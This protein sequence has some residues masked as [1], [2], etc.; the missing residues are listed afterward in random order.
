MI[1]PP[2]EHPAICIYLAYGESGRQFTTS[3]IIRTSGRGLASSWQVIQHQ[4][5][6]RASSI[7]SLDLDELLAL[8]ASVTG[9][10]S[11]TRSLLQPPRSIRYL[12]VPGSL[13]KL[14]KVLNR[15][16]V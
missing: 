2:Q 6:V 7:L 14:L 13:I 4:N 12:A 8:L 11:S 16:E 15:E 5:L 3:G 9:T 1:N 10:R